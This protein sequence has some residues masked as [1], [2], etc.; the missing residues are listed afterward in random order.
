MEY[1]IVLFIVFLILL[2]NSNTNETFDVKDSNTSMYNIHPPSMFQIGQIHLP[3]YN[4][5]KYIGKYP[6]YKYMF[7]PYSNSVYY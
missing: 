7:H 2:L 4:F 1:I 5:P 6:Y 3:F